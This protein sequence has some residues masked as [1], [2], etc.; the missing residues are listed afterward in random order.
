MF[1]SLIEPL[2]GAVTLRVEGSGPK[3]ADAPRE[4]ERLER[5]RFEAAPLISE[6]FVGGAELENPVN[7]KGTTDGRSVLQSERDCDSKFSEKIYD[8]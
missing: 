6:N 5:L 7:E 3:L 2:T 1:E 4:T 8:C